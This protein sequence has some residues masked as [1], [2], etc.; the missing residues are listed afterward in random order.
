MGCVRIYLQYKKSYNLRKRQNIK[1]FQLLGD[2]NKK[3]A[4]QVIYCF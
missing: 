1:Y 2:G 4:V 3:I